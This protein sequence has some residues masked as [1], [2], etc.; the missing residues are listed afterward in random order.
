M[1]LAALPDSAFLY[2][3]GDAE[4][5]FPYRDALGDVD[6]GLLAKAMQDIKTTIDMAPHLLSR[7]GR[8]AKRIAIH[9]ITGKG[10]ASELEYKS[11]EG[12]EFATEPSGIVVAYASAFESKD[13]GDDVI[14]VGAWLDSIDR[15]FKNARRNE[16]RVLLG[17]NKEIILGHPVDLGEDGHGLLTKSQYNLNTFWGSEA[18][19]LVEAGDLNVQSVGYLP[20][21]DT[22]QTKSFT[23]DD[24]GTRHL[25]RLEL[26]EYGPLPFA[27]HSDAF[28]V[29]VKS[30]LRHDTSFVNLVEQATNVVEDV[31]LEAEAL[32]AKRELRRRPE[33]R[34]LKTEQYDSLAELAEAGRSL[35]G[36]LD[37]LLKEREIGEAPAVDP[38]AAKGL[39]LALDLARARL[40]HAGIK[41][42]IIP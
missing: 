31:L 16:V 22:P 12:V 41:E 10:S 42:T 21:A 30:G 34:E 5:R 2:V 6:E 28:V 3:G 36:Q 27:M 40:Q 4:R 13:Q 18:F 11:A 39:K 29:G 33:D 15:K 25:H 37:L 9:K 1:K 23:Y 20:G 35:V 8:R 32:A 19:H 38:A 14:H 26:F 24:Y 7:L 17:H